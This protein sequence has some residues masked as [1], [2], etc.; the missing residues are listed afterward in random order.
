MATQEE[1]KQKQHIRYF[2]TEYPPV[3]VMRVDGQCSL[4]EYGS[5]N[6]R[7]KRELDEV[8]LKDMKDHCKIW[9]P[10]DIPKDLK[11][12]VSRKLKLPGMYGFFNEIKGYLP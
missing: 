11:M 12:P 5:Y 10:F 1:L 4:A 7:M 8:Q 3:R 9:K 2:Q 6:D